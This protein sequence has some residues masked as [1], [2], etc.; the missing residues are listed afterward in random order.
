MRVLNT[1]PAFNRALHFYLDDD[2]KQINFDAEINK[3]LI[4]FQL[5]YIIRGRFLFQ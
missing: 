4:G 2:Y 3:I 1:M 5:L